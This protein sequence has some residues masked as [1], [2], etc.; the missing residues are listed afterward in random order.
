MLRKAFFRL[1]RENQLAVR[2]HVELTATPDDDVSVKAKRVVDRGRQ[3]G[4]LG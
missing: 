1:F 4:G 2:C 3:T